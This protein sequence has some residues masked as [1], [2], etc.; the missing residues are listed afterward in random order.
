MSS[1][2]TARL[3]HES[4]I[5]VDDYDPLTGLLNEAADEIE[6]L[7]ADHPGGMT[8]QEMA[9]AIADRMAE[10]SGEFVGWNHMGGE[11]RRTLTAA[12]AEV[13]WSLI[14]RNEIQG[15]EGSDQDG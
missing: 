12:V 15:S 5:R 2:L 9:S 6:R 4:R 3:R 10:L 7:R 1:D 14:E 13:L 11:D 8:A